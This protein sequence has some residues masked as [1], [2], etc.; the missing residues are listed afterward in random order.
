MFKYILITIPFPHYQLGTAAME[1][2]YDLVE[3]LPAEFTRDV[4]LMPFHCATV[5]KAPGPPGG[6]PSMAHRSR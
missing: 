6:L 1:S 5:P 2:C 4:E 3:H